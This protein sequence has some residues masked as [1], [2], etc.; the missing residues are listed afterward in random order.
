MSETLTVLVPCFNESG[1]IRS[2]VEEIQ[3]VAPSLDI[4]VEILLLDDGSTDD[5]ATIMRE[6]CDEASNVAM[7]VNPRNLGVGRTIL[8]VY[9]DFPDDRWLTVF[10]GDGELIF[11]SIRAHLDV[12]RDYDL[13]LG[14]LQNSIIRPFHRRIASQ[15][16]TQTVNALY[17]YSYTYLNGMKLYRAS[18]FKDIDVVSSGHAFNAELLGKA[19]LRN[20]SLRIG[21]VPFRARG[22]AS[23]NSKAI[24]PRS[25]VQA[26]VDVYQ[27]Y[28]SVADYRDQVIRE[29][30]VKDE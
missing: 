12:R 26:I 11:D 28:Q 6:L 3:R 29:K 9:N 18:V 2:T 14:Y 21:E 20:P 1:N 5:T 17:G 8:N 25:I 13:V 4:D 19:L 30:A 16:F 10:P 7:R 23:G 22:R 27:G 24:R 15:S